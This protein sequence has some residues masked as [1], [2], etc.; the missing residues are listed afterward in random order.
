MEHTLMTLP[1]SYKALEPYMSEETLSFHHGKH[2]AGY[3]A[4]LNTLIKDSEY[5]EMSLVKIIK[6]S[7]GPIF[8]NAAQV[9]NHDFFWHG[10]LNEE[11]A[12]SVELSDSIE[13][14]F[15][16]IDAFKT[17][18][19]DAGVSLFGSGWVWLSIDKENV[20]HIEQ[21]GNADNPICTGRVPL[22]V[23]D[24]WEHAYY[25]DHRNAR[26]EYLLNWWQLVNWHFVSDNFATQKEK[27]NHYYIHEC[28]ENTEVCDYMS[29]L[30]ESERVSS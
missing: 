16:S 12:P 11:T 25:L 13:Q 8:N 14:Q 26:A 7:T 30:E 9:F 18:F 28:N 1:Y 5:A 23:C 4:K 24:I 10:L 22:M 21:T 2:H 15:G 17:A 27:R 19:I 29:S 3:V 6:K 20:L